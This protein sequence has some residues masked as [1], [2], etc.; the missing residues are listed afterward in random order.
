MRRP[1]FHFAAV[2]SIVPVA[3]RPKRSGRYM[4]STIGLRQHVVPGRH[5]AHHVGDRE[6]RRDR[7]LRSNAA[8]KRSSRNSL[9][10]GS[11]ASA[12]QD[13][14]S[15][16]ARR[17]QAR[18]VDLE[19]GRQIVGDD[20]AAELRLR[21]GHLQHHHEALV[22]LGLGGIGRL[23]VERVITALD[24]EAVLGGGLRRE[25]RAGDRHHRLHRAVAV[26]AHRQRRRR[27]R[28]RAGCGRTRPAASRR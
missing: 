18:I 2:I 4:S 11:T 8:V 21:L 10:T 22:L 28:R 12:I 1:A 23:A 25:R 27:V 13:E 6:H 14:R 16:I 24:L 20:H 7:S 17:H 5:R 26:V 3:V 15:G 19:A 9:F